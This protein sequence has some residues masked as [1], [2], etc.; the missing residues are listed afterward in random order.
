MSG[1]FELRTRAPLGT[2]DRARGSSDAERHRAA[3]TILGACATSLLRLCPVRPA[4]SPK[5]PPPRYQRR[6]SCRAPIAGETSVLVRQVLANQRGAAL[7]PPPPAG[8]SSALRLRSVYSASCPGEGGCTGGGK[9]D[10]SWTPLVGARVAWSSLL[11]L[12]ALLPS[13]F[14]RT[15]PA[16][17]APLRLHCSRR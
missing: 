5:K 9:G 12:L 8:S 14:L 11:V 16:V 4:P 1:F 15:S 3:L 2:R 7:S 6:V 13:P 17:S 10:E